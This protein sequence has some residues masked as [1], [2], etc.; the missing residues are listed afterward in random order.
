M[1]YLRKSE[2]FIYFLPSGCQALGPGMEQ[3]ENTRIKHTPLSWSLRTTS[4]GRTW[5]G[6][7]IDHGIQQHAGHWPPW[8]ANVTWWEGRTDWNGFNGEWEEKNWWQGAWTLF[9]FSWKGTK[10]AGQRWG[11]R[12]LSLCR[13]EKITFVWWW[14]KSSREREIV[15]VMWPWEGMGLNPRLRTKRRLLETPQRFLLRASTFSEK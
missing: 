3:C 7:K 8:Q 2:I 4:R 10:E 1:L 12:H 15:G 6:L 11:H 14:G 13:I 9:Q 5:W